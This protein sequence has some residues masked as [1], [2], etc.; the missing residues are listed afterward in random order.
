M[1]ILSDFF[2]GFERWMQ[3]LKS[4]WRQHDFSHLIAIKDNTHLNLFAMLP[5]DAKLTFLIDDSIPFTQE[6]L[7]LILINNRLK[8]I[9]FLRN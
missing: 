1:Y 9:I 3:K 2:N 5:E 8:M 4:L 6:E 7:K